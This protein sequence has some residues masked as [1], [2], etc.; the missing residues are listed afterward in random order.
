MLKYQLVSED[1]CWIIDFVTIWLC[2]SRL[3]ASSA[4]SVKSFV[5]CTCKIQVLGTTKILWKYDHI[6]THH[7]NLNWLSISHQFNIRSVC[8]MFCY[9]H[10]KEGCLFHPV[11]LAAFLSDYDSWNR[12]NFSNVGLYSL[13]STKKLFYT[14]TWWDSFPVHMHY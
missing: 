13:T 7:N 2:T 6:A 9:Y 14:A 4:K 12:E 10:Q 5:S 1:T 8:V 3:G 11:W